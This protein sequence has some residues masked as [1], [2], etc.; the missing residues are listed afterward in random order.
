MTKTPENLDVGDDFED[1]CS[2]DLEEC[3]ECFG[4]GTVLLEDDDT[5]DECPRCCGRGYL[6]Y[7]P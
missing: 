5:E 4:F 1:L 3:S 6:S 7:S 2:E